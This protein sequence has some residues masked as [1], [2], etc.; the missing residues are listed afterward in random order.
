MGREVGH[1]LSS[2]SNEQQSRQRVLLDNSSFQ[3]Q[4][5]EILHEE[6]VAVRRCIIQ[7]FI[8]TF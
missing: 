2:L 3:S 1:V 4:L 6:E 8:I 5:G 7:S